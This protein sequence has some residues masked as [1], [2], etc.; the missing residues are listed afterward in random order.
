MLNQLVVCGRIYNIQVNYDKQTILT[1]ATPRSYKN[2]EREY[3]TD[4][5]DFILSKGII[6]NVKEYCN[7]GD[8]IGVKG[9]VQTSIE[10]DKKETVLIA[11][12]VTFLTKQKEG[13]NEDN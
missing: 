11:E 8:I 7:N 5:I 3:E 13:N 12:R 2:E 1:I 6:E 10:G 4:Y 9:R